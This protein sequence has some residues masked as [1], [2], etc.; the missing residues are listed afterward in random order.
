MI[1]EF[2]V[3]VSM[4]EI[5]RRPRRENMKLVRLIP[6]TIPGGVEAYVALYVRA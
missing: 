5:H 6:R 1:R 2:I 3:G 4:L